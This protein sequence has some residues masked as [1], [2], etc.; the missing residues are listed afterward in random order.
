MNSATNLV[1]NI[2]ALMLGFGYNA[3]MQKL[4][5][6]KLRKRDNIIITLYEQRFTDRSLLTQMLLF[7]ALKF[8]I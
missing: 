7:G 2:Y 1:I 3:K 5:A 8:A 6:K 4:H